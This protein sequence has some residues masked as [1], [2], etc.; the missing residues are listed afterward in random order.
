MGNIL[1]AIIL[2]MIFFVHL[3]ISKGNK[4][5]TILLFIMTI[6]TV[7]PSVVGHS[8]YFSYVASLILIFSIFSFSLGSMIADT[9]FVKQTM[10]NLNL[11]LPYIIHNKL[12]FLIYFGI[13]AIFISTLLSIIQSCAENYLSYCYKRLKQKFKALKVFN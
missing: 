3:M 13:L 4:V 6:F 10:K 9:L 11:S 1:V 12:N 2:M 7:I 8:F 5:S